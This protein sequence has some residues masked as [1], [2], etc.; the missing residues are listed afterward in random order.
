[1]FSDSIIQFT[2]SPRSEPLALLDIQEVFI[3]I[4]SQ[5]AAGSFIAGDNSAVVHLERRAGPF[6]A[7]SAFNRSSKSAGLVVAVDQDQNFLE[8]NTV[9]TPTLSA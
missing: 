5:L 9:P 6:L 3:G 1:M 2:N 4:H 7:D 8:P